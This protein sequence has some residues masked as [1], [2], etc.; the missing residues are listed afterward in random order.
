MAQN[1]QKEK[2]VNAQQFQD[3]VAE[4]LSRVMGERRNAAI[5]A[6]GDALNA[7]EA[8]VNE[9][10]IKAEAKAQGQERLQEAKRILESTEAELVLEATADGRIDGKNKETRELQMTQLLH[11]EAGNGHPYGVALRASQ[12]AQIA[13]DQAGLEEHI[14]SEELA[15]AKVRCRL[16]EAQLL[17]LGTE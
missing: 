7:L 3:L 9:W 8:A 10:A 11:H 12:L 6:A 4:V 17:A 14:A 16:V 13:S 15:A 5:E 2:I 1:S